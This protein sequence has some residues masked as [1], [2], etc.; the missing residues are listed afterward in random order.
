MT[1]KYRREGESL[2][3]I[4]DNGS[5][6]VKAGISGEELPRVVFPSIVG[7]SMYK[8]V[9]PGMNRSGSNTYVGDEAQSKVF[10]LR[11]FFRIFVRFFF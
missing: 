10:F 7:K 6:M 2:S 11:I 9:L 8:S 5:G 4:I 3:V 1:T